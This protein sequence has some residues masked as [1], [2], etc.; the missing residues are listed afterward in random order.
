MKELIELLERRMDD[1]ALAILGG[2]MTKEEYDIAI[3]TRTIYGSVIDMIKEMA[4]L[5]DDDDDE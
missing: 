3:N 1:A 2:R 5:E 4:Y